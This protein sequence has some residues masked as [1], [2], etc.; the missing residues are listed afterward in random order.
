MTLRTFRG[1]TRFHGITG[2]P[3]P[4]FL[5]MPAVGINISDHSV[6]MMELLPSSVGYVVGSYEDKRIPD[7]VVTSG[8]IQDPDKLKQALRELKEQY[9]I[10]FVRASI[11]EEKAYIFSVRLPNMPEEDIHDALAL[12]LQ[13]HVP[14]ESSESV[15]DYDI[16]DHTDNGNIDVNVS[17]LPQNVVASFLSVFEGAGLIPLSFEVEAQAIRRAV[18]PLDQNITCMIVDVGRTRT[19]ISIIDRGFVR[20]TSTFSM[21]GDMLTEAIA[22]QKDISFEKADHIKQEKGFK[23]TGENQEF[24][25][26][27]V[28]CVSALRDEINRRVDYWHTHPDRAGNT[29]NNIKKII[30]CGGNASV[31]G[32]A[33]HLAESLNIKVEIAN[34]WT[35]AFGFDDYIPQVDFRHSL[36]YASAVGLAL[37]HE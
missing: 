36:A 27:L 30:L 21:G 12:Q 20:F 4:A 17:V 34:V 23:N 22:R 32:L 14:L 7:G 37:S 31:P 19:G 25:M 9:D 35:N 28:N 10:T 24:Y 16:V 11:P 2:F 26:A 3:P 5:R 6:K 15:F 13:E 1:N 18:L 33:E 8:D 29:G